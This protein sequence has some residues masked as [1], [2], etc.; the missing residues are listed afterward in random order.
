MVRVKSSILEKTKNITWSILE[1]HLINI[2]SYK[3]LN[4]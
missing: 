2:L 4:I 3:K 1:I